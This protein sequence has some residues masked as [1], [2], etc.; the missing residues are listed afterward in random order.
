MR[1]GPLRIPGFRLLVAG[2]FASMLGDCCYAVALPWLVLGGHGG[3]ALLGT[4][5]ACYGVARVATIPLGGVLADRW[6]GRRIMLGA[7]AVRAAAVA[8]LAAVSATGEPGT[9]QLLLPALLLGAGSGLFLPASYTLLPGLLP[10]DQLGRGNALS[11]MANQFG[12]V[13][14]PSLGGLL[15]AL[16]G[17]TP[18]LL[19]DAG[20]FALSAAVLLGLR[21]ARAERAGG[22]APDGEGPGF[23][24][25]L[26]RGRLLHVVMVVALV[27]N[28]AF[29]GTMEVAL[30]DWAHRD[31][32]PADYGALLTVL[33]IGSLLGSAIAVRARPAQRPARLFAALAAVMGLGL[34]GVPYA[35][36]VVGAGACIAVYSVAGGWQNIVVVTMLQTWTP[37]R[38]LGRVMSMVMLAV[39]GSFPVSVALAGLAVH[40]LGPAPFFPAAGAVI[41]LA[42]ALALAQPAFRGHR[43]GAVFAGGAA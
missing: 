2:Q 1:D 6:G 4:V 23:A 36:G 31:L 13:L 22:P 19:V 28:L 17:A 25:V 7:D 30:P 26:R 24:E 38:L 11:T 18:A 41:A 40:R 29:N 8:G 20:S 39:T 3:T 27:C 16:W 14:G 33:S 32:G 15:V 9:L 34:A 42:V 43:H 35:G 10:A 5:L 21:P 12:G 37:A